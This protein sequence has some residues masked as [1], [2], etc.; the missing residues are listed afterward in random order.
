MR[1]AFAQALVDLAHADSRIVLLTADLGFGVLDDFA[2]THPQRFFNVG[3]AEANMVGLATGLAEAGYI[4]FLYSIATFASLRPFEQ[5]RNGPSLHHLPVRLIGIGGGFEYGP[6]GVTHAALEDIGAM[7]LLPNMQIIVPADERQACSALQSTYAAPHPIYFRIS[8]NEGIEI[9]GLSADFDAEDIDII[10]RGKDVLIVTS[11][12]IA[13]EALTAAELLAKRE[14][15]ATVAVV[16]SLQPAPLKA[17]AAL[18]SDFPIVTT[19]EAHRSNGGLGSLVAEYIADNG[20]GCRLMR[21]AVGGQVEGISG[22]ES[23]MNAHFGL[24][25][26]SISTRILEAI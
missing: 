24:D 8:K 15:S 23:Y 9:P 25:A 7:R 1:K 14:V 3:V 26:A 17:L 18:L 19:V 11:G 2:K 16:S 4:P 6:N 10:H 21:C 12:P 22:S 5:L 13:R 20:I